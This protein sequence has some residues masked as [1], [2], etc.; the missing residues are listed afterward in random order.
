MGDNNNVVTI[1]HERFAK[2]IKNAEKIARVQSDESAYQKYLESDIHLRPTQ[3]RVSYVS[4]NSNSPQT[5]AKLKKIGDQEKWES[6]APGRSTPEKKLQS[7]L[8]R[9]VYQNGRRMAAIEEI[10]K[11]KIESSREI[12][13]FFVVDEIAIYYDGNKRAVCDLLALRR[14]T[15][16]DGS[17][18]WIPMQIELKTKRHPDRLV[19]QLEYSKLFEQ[20][21]EDCFLQA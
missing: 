6:V 5:R 13:V 8:L 3:D 1:N 10:V 18:L 4:I 12:A 11:Q 20:L 16:S 17:Y 21:K 9:N 15:K 14:E 19:N 7:W 2:I